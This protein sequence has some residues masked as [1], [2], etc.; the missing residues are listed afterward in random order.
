[1][2][3]IIKNIDVEKSIKQALNLIYPK[4]IFDCFGFHRS[5]GLD[6]VYLG[7]FRSDEL[8]AIFFYPRDLADNRLDFLVYSGIRYCK[9]I[10]RKNTA[11]LISQRLEI[12]E[13]VA[14]YIVTKN[15]R[16]SVNLS[17]DVDDIR[18]FNWQN[19]YNDKTI[20]TIEIRYTSFL[21]IKPFFD[22]NGDFDSTMSSVVASKSRRQVIRKCLA[23]PSTQYG[24]SPSIAELSSLY[25][26]TKNE[27]DPLAETT[28]HE[29][30]WFL[31]NTENCYVSY[32]Q[33]IKNGSK[34]FAVFSTYGDVPVYL[35]GGHRRVSGDEVSGT[36]CVL[37]GIKA[38]Y[39]NGF[40]MVDL[41][42]INS[43]NRGW[44]KTSF[45][46]DL[47]PYYMISSFQN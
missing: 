32:A 5:I 41:E 37:N 7:V 9:T 23:D 16:I 13:A 26:E 45:G 3:L 34:S 17:P 43:P 47:K 38:L 29:T 19:F 30:M 28:F 44:F 18:G 8:L 35:F 12:C 1:M 31:Q 42:G 27:C 39:K 14:S 6:L 36:A 10:F 21:N 11:Q 22:V 15:L 2:A 4:T 40:Y 46:G 24:K 25:F 33:N 20:F